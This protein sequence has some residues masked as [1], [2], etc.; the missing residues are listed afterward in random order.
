MTHSQR[1]RRCFLAGIVAALVLGTRMAAAE[2]P[3]LTLPIDCTVGET[4]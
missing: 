4:C 2:A 3:R 1:Q